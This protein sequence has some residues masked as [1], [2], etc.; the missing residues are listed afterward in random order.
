MSNH[1]PLEIV[2][3]ILH[4][5][6]V[7]SI[8]KCTSVCKAW[9]SLIT[10][11]TFIYDHLNRTIQAPNHN[12]SLFFQFMEFIPSPCLRLENAYS[13]SS[14]VNQQTDQLSVEL[15]PLSHLFDPDRY[16]LFVSTCNGLVC[17][18]DY[19][20]LKSATIIIW[21]PLLRKYIVL[22]KPITTRRKRGRQDLCCYVDRN[23]DFFFG[24]GFDSRNNDYKVVRV[25]ND[26][27]TK[28]APHVQVYSLASHIWRSI[29]VTVPQFF[30][31]DRSWLPSV[32]LNGA[33]HWLVW[34]DVG[35][36]YK[37]IL[38]FDVIQETFREFTLPQPQ[39]NE[40]HPSSRLL[41]VEG[42]HSLA[43]VN[44][45]GRA[46]C[47]WV[48][49]DYGITNSWTEIFRLDTELYGD[50]CRVLSLT[51][52]GKVFLKLAG[53]AVVLVDPTKESKEPVG[54]AKWAFVS[55]SSFVQSLFFLNK[56]PHV[57]SF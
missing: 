12:S 30:L 24:F 2:E 31:I 29:S 22:P 19:S 39:S 50:I 43:V 1:L 7:K 4:R 18:A 17:S 53:G 56:K 5:L 44:R 16:T 13:L 45:S 47:I 23:Y 20:P 11:Q 36:N 49:K 40:T 38:S 8:V 9:N 25:M 57:L 21:N 3:E 15:F 42:G 55:L 37:F 6:P 48:M 46:F 41:P 14:S 27:C 34:R 35:I 28:D 33:L 26:R 32:F 54:I 10:H 52:S 51:S